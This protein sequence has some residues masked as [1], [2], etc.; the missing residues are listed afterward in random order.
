MASLNIIQKQLFLLLLRLKTPE[1]D[2]LIPA[3]EVDLTRQSLIPKAGG[4][5]TGER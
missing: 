3:S 5:G 4:I 1:I 2:A